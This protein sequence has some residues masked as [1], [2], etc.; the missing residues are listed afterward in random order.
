MSQEKFINSKLSM[1]TQDKQSVFSEIAAPLSA[2]MEKGDVSKIVKIPSD[3]NWFKL[4]FDAIQVAEDRMIIS[5]ERLTDGLI[6]IPG[7]RN[8]G[9]YIVEFN[10]TRAAYLRGFFE[11]RHRIGGWSFIHWDVR[12]YA[13]SPLDKKARVYVKNFRAPSE[14]KRL[15]MAMEGFHGAQNIVNSYINDNLS[16]FQA[17][18]K[19]GHSVT[20]IELAWSKGLMENLGYRYVEALGQ[21][22]NPCDWH[23]TEVHWCK[24]ECDLIGGKR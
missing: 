14:L 15:I 18:I 10:G 9:N 8:H 4:S 24:Q 21:G 3:N 16:R 17:G 20:E 1:L 13:V 12:S 23:K 6:K 2:M 22:S 19:N 7:D 11:P 5:A